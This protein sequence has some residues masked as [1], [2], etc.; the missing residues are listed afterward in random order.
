MKLP[1]LGDPGRFPVGPWP[2]FPRTLCPSAQ[3]PSE[4]CRKKIVLHVFLKWPDWQLTQINLNGPEK[5]RTVCPKTKN[6][7]YGS[8]G[9]VFLRAAKKKEAFLAL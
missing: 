5:S 6:K 2:L 1:F 9:T 7:N 8:L 4:A 3:D